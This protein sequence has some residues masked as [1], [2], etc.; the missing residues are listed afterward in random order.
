VRAFLCFAL[1]AIAATGCGPAGSEL[2]GTSWS[3][4]RIADHEVPPEGRAVVTF[5]GDTLQVDLPCAS[6]TAGLGIDTDG[7]A[8]SLRD[9]DLDVACDGNT[10]SI[11]HRQLDALL[12]VRSWRR[13][14]DDRI[15]L[16]GRD[17][18][19]MQRVPE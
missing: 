2:V 5:H 11:E 19:F 14:K 4:L 13:E 8:L 7:P 10:S 18:L 3:V 9:T 17:D 15:V 12:E 6:V 1:F 16:E